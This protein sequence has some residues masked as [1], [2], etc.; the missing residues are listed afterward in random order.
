MSCTANA[1]T[2][3]SLRFLST[4]IASACNEGLWPPTVT[5]RQ[6]LP[7]MRCFPTPIAVFVLVI[8]IC[9]LILQHWQEQRYFPRWLQP[10]LSALAPPPACVP[11]NWIIRESFTAYPS[12]V[13]SWYLQWLF[14]YCHLV[15]TAQSPKGTSGSR[16]RE[17][18]E[19]LQT[20]TS[21]SKLN[22]VAISVHSLWYER[23]WCKQ[24]HGRGMLCSQQNTFF[25]A[26]VTA[27]WPGR[28]NA[29][30][31]WRPPAWA[32]VWLRTLLGFGFSSNHNSAWILNYP[33]KG[34]A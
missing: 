22:S 27:P 13:I 23:S 24:K 15:C 5:V 12:S 8:I 9:R 1:P 6:H 17:K 19:Q 30:A 7:K 21:S 18:H 29:T 25:S 33:E 28:W 16:M 10:T 26:S 2:V 14:I 20:F 3:H 34:K 4:P 32:T 31:E 11:G